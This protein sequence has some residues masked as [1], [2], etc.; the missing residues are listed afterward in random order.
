MSRHRV[1]LSVPPDGV[2][3]L[4]VAAANKKGISDG[5]YFAARGSGATHIET[6]E[7]YLL[8]VSLW[9]Y[10]ADRLSGFTHD[11]TVNRYT[12]RAGGRISKGRTQ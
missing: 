1:D 9:A 6:L 7:A 12:Q 2:T 10:R 4:E 8:G 11:Q 3:A 5:Y